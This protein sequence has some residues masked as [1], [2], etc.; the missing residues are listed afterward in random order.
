MGDGVLP[1]VPGNFQ[2]DIVRTVTHDIQL[3]LVGL[4]DAG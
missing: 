4:P 2:I 1:V 3:G